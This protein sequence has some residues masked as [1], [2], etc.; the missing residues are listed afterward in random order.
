MANQTT[1]RSH[2]KAELL[3]A[4]RTWEVA[5]PT[6]IRVDGAHTAPQPAALVPFRIGLDALI[7]RDRSVRPTSGRLQKRFPLTAK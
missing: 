3:H 2:F 5:P 6:T 4:T 7:P 1:P